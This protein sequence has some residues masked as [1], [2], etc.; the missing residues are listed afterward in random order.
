M[1]EGIPLPE[2]YTSRSPSAIP[3]R[4]RRRGHQ[5][6]KLVDAEVELVN[7][8]LPSGVVPKYI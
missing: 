7:L 4:D 5:G 8:E 3:D 6:M 1:L 2:H